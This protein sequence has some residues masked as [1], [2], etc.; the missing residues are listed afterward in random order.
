MKKNFKQKLLKDPKLLPILEA[1]EQHQCKL[2]VRY[3]PKARFFYGMFTVFSGGYK[4]IVLHY[5]KN[6]NYADMV[7]ALA[8]EAT[9]LF[10]HILGL[11]KSYHKHFIVAVAAE[12]DADRMAIGI[13]RS[14]YPNF[15]I[16]NIR[17]RYLANLPTVYQSLRSD[18][19]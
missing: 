11:Y 4:E 16:S 9:H 2:H 15:K 7:F 18:F 19:N 3:D 5:A 13:V 17:V 1:M 8:H 12:R 6:S 10:Q 14:A